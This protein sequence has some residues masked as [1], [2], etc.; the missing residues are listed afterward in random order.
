MPKARHHNEPSQR[1]LRVSELLR[2]GL[3]EVFLRADIADPDLE[4]AVITVSEVRVSPDLRNATAF[5]VPLG[6]ERQEAV[7]AALARNRRYLRGELA[8][9]V[10]LKYM[11]DLVFRLDDTFDRTDRLEALLRSGKVSR[12][13]D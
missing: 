2:K 5:V 6:G 11:P 12:D 9:R 7:V 3:S 10:T 4:G 8:R 1:Q 13:L